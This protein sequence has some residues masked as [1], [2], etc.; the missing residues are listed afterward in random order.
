M[1]VHEFDSVSG[2]VPGTINNTLP[3]TQCAIGAGDLITMSSNRFAKGSYRRRM[4][5]TV[6]MICIIY[7]ASAYAGEIRFLRETSAGFSHPHDLTLDNSGKYLYIADLDHDVVQVLNPDSLSIVGKIGQGELHSPHDVAFDDKGR[8]LVADSGNNRI[9]I[10]ELNGSKGRLVSVLTGDLSSPEGVT[11]GVEGSVYVS[12]T[13]NHRIVQFKQQNKIKQIGSYGNNH[14]QFIRPHDIEMGADGLLYIADP[15]NNRIEVYN[16]ALEFQRSISNQ[17]QA[18]NEPKYLALDPN[19]QLYIA[20]QNNNMV[21]I[22]D[23]SQH[24]IAIVNQAGK[25]ALNMIEGVE[26]FGGKI[27]ISDTYNNRIVVFDLN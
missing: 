10:Y 24:E 4:W 1:A 3:I 27:W 8:L 16:A 12:S 25:Q 19:N 18:Y 9:A 21:R 7:L 23:T 26:V 20:D 22:L 2:R 11:A 13:G 17:Q 15:G 6:L 14:G 5:I